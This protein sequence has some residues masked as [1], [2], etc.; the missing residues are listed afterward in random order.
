MD[1]L[2]ALD[3]IMNGNNPPHRD[4]VLASIVL[5][6]L[7]ETLKT[8]YLE[9]HEIPESSLIDDLDAYF[10]ALDEAANSILTLKSLS[11]RLLNKGS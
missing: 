2:S 11:E 3:E 9:S 5:N 8:I 10:I 1:Y 6:G 4:L 7:L